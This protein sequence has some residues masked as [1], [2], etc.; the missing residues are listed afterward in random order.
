M[1]FYSNLFGTTIEN[2]RNTNLNVTQ[3]GPTLTDTHRSLLDCKFTR[4]EVKQVLFSIPNIKAP[5]MDD[6]VARLT[7]VRKK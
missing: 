7:L 2:R 4:E 1:D 3:F 5:G 6:V